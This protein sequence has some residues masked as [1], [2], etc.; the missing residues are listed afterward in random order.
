MSGE[1]WIFWVIV[2]GVTI[3]VY[4]MR[5]EVKRRRQGRQ[6]IMAQGTNWAKQC[7]AKI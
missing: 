3:T 6:G 7:L 5:T 1:F 2:V 4:W